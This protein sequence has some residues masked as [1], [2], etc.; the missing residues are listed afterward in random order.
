[1]VA[2]VERTAIKIKVLEYLSLVDFEAIGVK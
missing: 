1:M 2:R